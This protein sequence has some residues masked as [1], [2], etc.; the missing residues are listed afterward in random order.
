MTPSVS[1]TVTATPAAATPTC[2][3]LLGPE[4]WATTE[5]HVRQVTV[6]TSPLGLFEEYGGTL[7]AWFAGDEIDS[8]YGFSAISEADQAAQEAR[9]TSEGYTATSVDGG[10]RYAFDPAQNATAGQYFFRDG[11]WWTATW[12]KSLD[13]IITSWPGR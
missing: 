11:M 8:Y 1:P 7:C 9:L 13:T 3:T 5:G 10:T 6:T 12:E 2:E 4:H